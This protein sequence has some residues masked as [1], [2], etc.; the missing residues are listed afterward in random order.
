MKTLHKV[1]ISIGIGSLLWISL[2]FTAFSLKA[3]NLTL[4]VNA[5]R[6]RILSGVGGQRIEMEG[7]GYLMEP[8]KPL[9]PAKNFLIALPP[10]AQVQSVEVRG[11]GAE[12]LPGIY[13]IMPSPPIMP[14]A[15]PFQSSQLVARLQDEWKR[16]RETVY[17]SDQVYPPERGRL[18]GLG[19]LRKY[20][21][22]AVS[23][24]PFS[25]YPQ[26][27]RLIHYRA[28]QITVNY[29]RP[30]LGSREAERVE[31]LKWDT[32]ADERAARLFINYEGMKALYQPQGS[33][34]KGWEQTYDYLIITTSEL[35]SA[36]TSSD[37]I[38]WK[39]SLG[40]KV[41]VVLT[42]DTEIT[43][44][45][46]GDLAEKIRNFLRAYYGPWGIEYVL[47]VGDYTTVPMR[48]CYPNPDY[49]EHNPTDPSNP[50]GSVPTD[51]YYADLSFPDSISWDSDGDGFLGEYG[52]DSP[53]F[54]A[55]VYVGR[56][57][58]SDITLI[59]YALNKVVSF[60]QDTTTWKNQALQGGAILFY[61]NQD[62]S[63]YPMVDG[64]RCLYH[65]ETE[66][67]NGWMISH[68]SEQGGLVPSTYVWPALSY[69]AFANDWRNGEY[70]V[71]NWAGHGAPNAA[72]RLLWE[73]D[74]GD[75][76]PETDGSDQINYYSFIATSSNL[77][78]DHPSI[79]FA[80]S[81]NVGYPEP[82]AQG[83]LGIDLLTKP[84]WGSSIGVVSATRGAAVTAYWDSIP[85]GAESICY[86]FNHYMINGP[87]GPEKV[88]D[89]LYNSKAYVHYNF[90]WDH[91]YEYQNMFDY[92][93]YGD[94]A[95]VRGGI[96]VGAETERFVELPR[97]FFLMQN[98]PNPFNSTTEIKYVLPT[99]CQVR[100]QVY[101]IL[102]HRVASLVDGDKKAGYQTII[103]DASSLS[104]GVYFCRLQA[105]DF[106]QTRKMVLLK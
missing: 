49:H 64:A 97:S 20:A 92:N 105:G 42:T 19:S 39:R 66:L 29:S 35:L 68:Y 56:I 4:T 94:P 14:L 12:Q 60:E 81:C 38:T 27:G 82:N 86:E 75:S 102:G 51:C 32:V 26:S 47:L 103:W 71:V 52:E 61:E 17:S 22:A 24:Y 65:M 41:M 10:G 101:N 44:Q 79:V 7:F 28:A 104:S 16:S 40:Y 59:T 74:D 34:P 99:D 31:E 21:Y 50:G 77:D 30:S 3:E 54:L 36:I 57:P 67:M 91:F 69:E 84:N 25:Y 15:D 9:L 45:P 11:I 53:D 83:N 72:A 33:R 98:N 2:V 76:I 87:G 73:W 85:G 1:S 62:S 89:A 55:E 93:L 78:D 58:T 6:Y 106:E 37:F 43:S 8:G 95:L 46:G 5:G 100:L 96:S 13:R 23:F 18:K 48:Y 63:G 88:G 90:G 80:I 70:A